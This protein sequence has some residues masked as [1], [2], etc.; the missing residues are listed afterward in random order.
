MLSQRIEQWAEGY[1]ATG[2]QEG[3]EKGLEQGLLKGEARVLARQ[4]T[5]RFGVLPAWVEPRLADATEAQL[6]RWSEAILDA[7]SLSAVFEQ[8]P[9]AH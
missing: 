8:T 2:R 9:P 3:L 1:I 5:R 7:E 6:E 4:L